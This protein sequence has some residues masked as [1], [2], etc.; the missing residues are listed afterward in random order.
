MKMGGIG[1]F[2]KGIERTAQMRKYNTNENAPGQLDAR[3]WM[4]GKKI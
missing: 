1:G 4:A 3:R 2:G